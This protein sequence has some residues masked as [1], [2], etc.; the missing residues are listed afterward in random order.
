MAL[1]GFRIDDRLLH[2]QVVENWI[3]ELRPDRLV[4]ADDRAA[5]DPLTRQLY[6]AAI[7]G[8]IDLVVVPVAAARAAVSGFAG[9]VFLI[10]GS[11]AEALTL[12]EA[13]IAAAEI[14]VGGLHTEG[15]RELVNFIYA[16]DRDRE[17]LRRLAAAGV[18]LIAQDVPRRRRQ[19]LALLL[20]AGA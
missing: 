11:A 6:E 13:G 3:E 2:G 9:R 19:D 20:G 16:D 18:T 1:V 17:A 12:V 8:G 14:T 7:P 15:G 5:A 4:V 10:V